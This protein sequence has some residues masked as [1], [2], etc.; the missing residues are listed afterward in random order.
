MRLTSTA[1]TI[2]CAMAL[3]LT[4][5]AGM[6]RLDATEVQEA[7]TKSS[8]DLLKDEPADEK[9]CGEAFPS[10]PVY[11]E[12]VVDKQRR[13]LRAYLVID[14]FTRFGARRIATDSD[15]PVRDASLL[16][17]NTRL[18][19]DRLDTLHQ[20]LLPPSQEEHLKNAEYALQQPAALFSVVGVM[21]AATRP[22]RSNLFGL[23]SQLSLREI[24][25]NAPDIIR[26]GFRDLLYA[27][28]Y[29]DALMSMVNATSNQPVQMPEEEYKKWKD[30]LLVQ[31]D[32]H[33]TQLETMANGGQAIADKGGRLCGYAQP[34]KAKET[35]AAQ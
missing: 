15:N 14:A 33:C 30:A 2:A 26:N 31:I 25:T 3:T 21:Q 12:P 5:C 9:Q 13:L 23:V 10:K 7:L 16:V 20:L 4:G 18:A 29:A 6:A 28:A 32:A 24:A 8:C 1:T 27:N 22:V 34:V 11:T 19:L 17:N 35:S